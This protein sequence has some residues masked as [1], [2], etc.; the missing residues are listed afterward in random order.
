M[1]A[2]LKNFVI[3]SEDER[4]A[5]FI[6]AALPSRSRRTSLFTSKIARLQKPIALRCRRTLP[7]HMK[8]TLL[9]AALAKMELGPSTALRPK[10][11][12]K[13]IS[14]LAP[15]KMTEFDKAYFR[16]SRRLSKAP[17]EERP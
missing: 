4:N 14:R 7:A 8:R 11:S 1:N 6:W 12:V 9:A 17:E 16:A 10:L 13:E 5:L 3:L 2:S 15:L